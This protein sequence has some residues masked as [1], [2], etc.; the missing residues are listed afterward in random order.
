MAG[1]WEALAQFLSERPT[2][3]AET[4]YAHII[5][6]MNKGDP[7]LLPEE[8]LAIA[9]GARIEG[10]VTVTSGKAIVKFDEKRSSDA[11]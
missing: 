11:A 10:A 8:V 7:G 2:A 9:N 1:E 4:I 5:Q 6:S 3:E